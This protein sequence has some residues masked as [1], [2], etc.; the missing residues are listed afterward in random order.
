MAYQISY[1]SNNANLV[2]LKQSFSS[3]FENV[4]EL[5]LNLKSI[6]KMK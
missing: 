4:I 6:F 5:L 1:N 3:I 2:K